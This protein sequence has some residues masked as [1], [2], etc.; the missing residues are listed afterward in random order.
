MAAQQA[1]VVVVGA[2]IIGLTTAVRLAELGLP[3]RIV[4]DRPPARTT[5]AVAGAL[6]EP[7]LVEHPDQDRWGRVAY[8]RFAAEAADP[9]TGVRIVSGVDAI[10]QPR[11][12]PAWLRAMPGF[13]EADPAGLPDGFAG[14]WRFTTALIDMPVYLGFLGDRLAR[15]GVPV[16]QAHV[17]DLGLLTATAPVVVNCT[18]HRAGALTGDAAVQPV[19][20]QI[21]VVRNPGIT[22]FFTGTDASGGLTYLLPHGDRLLIGGSAEAGADRPEPDERLGREILDRAIALFPE[23]AG[24]E[25]LGQ[26]VGYRPYRAPIRVEQE[27]CGDGHVIHNYGHGG[28]GVTLSW[29]SAEDVCAMA[30]ELLG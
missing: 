22:E 28:A 3:V 1:P 19:R 18:G 27:E 24:A 4:T 12:A 16:D 7:Y 15:L 11:P 2:G 14:G 25:V 6:W 8:R 5:S 30:R 10:R 23:L 9:G 17:T 20:G 26:R 29:G 21:V 13:A